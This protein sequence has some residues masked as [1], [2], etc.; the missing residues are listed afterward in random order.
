MRRQDPVPVVIDYWNR[1]AC[2][3]DS[4][5][6]GQGKSSFSRRLDRA[7]RRDIYQ[8][9]QWTMGAAGD[10][11]GRSVIDVGC[12]PGR[13]ATEFVKRGARRVVGLDTAPE[14]LRLARDVVRTDGTDHA[15]EWVQSDILD[16][17][18]GETFD[19]S[20]AMGLWDYVADPRERL[21][22]I[23]RVTTG[24]FLS[25][26]PRLWTWR[27]PVRKIRLELLEGCPVY[28]F[29]RLQVERL[30]AENGFHVESCTVIGKLYCV[31]ARPA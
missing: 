19:V 16:Y 2:E 3:F 28:F 9:W 20:V 11:A 26:W 7:F 14:M 21:A 25:S 23:R 17:Q 1:V 22:A 8:R 6:T 18:T 5:Y 13:F 12:G 10:L 30:L 4:I 29:T 27:A 15:C 24:R 31:D